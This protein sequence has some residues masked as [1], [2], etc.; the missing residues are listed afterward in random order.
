MRSI[1]LISNS[2]DDTKAIGMILGKNLSGGDVLELNSDLGGGKTTLVHGVVSGF[3]SDDAVSSPS[4]TICNTYQA[5]DNRT[6]S[7]FDF[8]R[9][10]EAGIVSSELIESIDDLLTLVIV[11]WGDVVTSVLPSD[12]VSAVISSRSNTKRVITVI[13]PERHTRLFE[14]LQSWRD[15]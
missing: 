15:T 13:C 3:G 9:L 1:D 6:V 14:A 10:E 8:Y 4:F 7:H 2:V 5:N 11:E 12:K